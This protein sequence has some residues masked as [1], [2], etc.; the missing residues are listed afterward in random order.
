[1]ATSQLVKYNTSMAGEYSVCAEL[2]KK[3]Y[4]VSL[5]FGNA[6]AADVIVFLENN[7]YARIEVKTSN[8]TRVVTGFFQK[9]ASKTQVPHP[10]FWVLVYIDKNNISH[11]YVF[12]HEEMGNEQL[13]RNGMTSWSKVKGVDNVLIKDLSTYENAWDKIPK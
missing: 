8:T 4:N 10:D 6:K 9:Y 5:T 1:M 3:G 2:S 7:K 11:Y 12:T 13:C